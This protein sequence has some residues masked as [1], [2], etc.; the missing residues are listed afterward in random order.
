MKNKTRK[1]FFK[2]L[3]AWSKII[4]TIIAMISITISMIYAIRVRPY[5]N[6]WNCLIAECRIM[7]GNTKN[8][9]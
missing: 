2:G 4:L 7:K 9:L 3:I 8:E 6:D 5:D 1:N